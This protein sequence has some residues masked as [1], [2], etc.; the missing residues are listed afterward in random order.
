MEI[1]R[2]ICQYY[3]VGKKTSERFENVTQVLQSG[4]VAK[5]SLTTI[6]ANIT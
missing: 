4:N 5:C 3:I 6:D 1:S 2:P